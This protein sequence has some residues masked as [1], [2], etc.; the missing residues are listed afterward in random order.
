MGAHTLGTFRGLAEPLC[1]AR[2]HPEPRRVPASDNVR[3]LV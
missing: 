1:F 3:E 2:T